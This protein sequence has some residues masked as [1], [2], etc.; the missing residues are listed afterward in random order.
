[1]KQLTVSPLLFYEGFS[2]EIYASTS[3]IIG[4]TLGGEY[5]SCVTCCLHL[6]TLR[7]LT[8]DTPPLRRLPVGIDKRVFFMVV[9]L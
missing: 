9:L 7:S 2:G 3:V 4:G 1:M 6:S 5:L 8:M